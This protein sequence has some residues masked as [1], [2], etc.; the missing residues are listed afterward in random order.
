MSVI[1]CIAIWIHWRNS[2]K[3]QLKADETL[4]SDCFQTKCFPV[5]DIKNCS[6][7]A[8]YWKLSPVGVLVTFTIKNGTFTEVQIPYKH[9]EEIKNEMN[10]RYNFPVYIDNWTTKSLLSDS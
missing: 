10:K 6:L 8:V 1:I 4:F 3:L 5:A 7:E 2:A 9:V